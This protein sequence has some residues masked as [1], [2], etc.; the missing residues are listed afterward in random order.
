MHSGCQLII[1]IR[2][3]ENHQHQ[4]SMLISTTIRPTNQPTN[5]ANQFKHPTNNQPDNQQTTNQ[6]NNQSD[7]W[8]L[9]RACTSAA[10][11]IRHRSEFETIV[12]VA[13]VIQG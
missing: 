4:H 3:K 12:P 2:I 1:L 9:I 7:G 13:K 6:T 11:P 8:L 5:Q 10:Q